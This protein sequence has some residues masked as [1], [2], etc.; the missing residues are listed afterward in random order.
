MSC[1]VYDTGW[2]VYTT[3]A[4]PGPKPS[5]FCAANTALGNRAESISMCRLTLNQSEVAHWSC[6]FR[7]KHPIPLLPLKAAEERWASSAL[8]G[9]AVQLHSAQRQSAEILFTAACD[10]AASSLVKLMH[11]HSQSQVI[12]QLRLIKSWHHVKPCLIGHAA[13]YCCRHKS[14]TSSE[15]LLCCCKTQLD[16]DYCCCNLLTLQLVG[17]RYEKCSALSLVTSLSS[18]TP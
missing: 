18:P 10:A 13:V 12:L 9:C 8:F 14:T 7:S 5:V 4:S 15:V 6:L 11:D 2:H 17:T 1:F 3:A 16:R